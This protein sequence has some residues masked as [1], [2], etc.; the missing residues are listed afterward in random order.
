[1]NLNSFEKPSP[2]NINIRC[3][4]CNKT[5]NYQDTGIN[6]LLQIPLH[7]I[8]SH[9]QIC[10]RSSQEVSFHS[11]LDQINLKFEKLR[12]SLQK[13]QKD[14]GTQQSLYRFFKQTKNL[15]ENAIF[16]TLEF[17]SQIYGFVFFKS[18]I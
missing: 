10:V 17:I 16:N 18:L 9:S 13:I 3:I 7:F 12:Q 2:L 4:N 15:D 8:D 14:I 11:S 1:M 5:I 6:F